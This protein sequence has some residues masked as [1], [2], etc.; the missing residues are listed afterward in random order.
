MN[1]KDALVISHN[2][3]APPDGLNAQ[4]RTCY[5]AIRSVICLVVVLLF[6]AIIATYTLFLISRMTI[7]RVKG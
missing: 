1:Y 3:H 4:V 7:I 5:H 2:H 6:N